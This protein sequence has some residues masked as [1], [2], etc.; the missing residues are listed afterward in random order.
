MIKHIVCF[1]LKNDSIELRNK[2]RDILL[3]M[4]GRVPMLLDLEVGID[5]LSSQRS[6]DII[7]ETYFNN[8]EDL[9]KY[10]NDPYHCEVVKTHM[11]ANT[12]ASIAVD[13]EIES[14]K[15][16]IDNHK[17]GVDFWNSKRELFEAFYKEF[18]EFI[19]NHNGKEDLEK[20]KIFSKEDFYAY[21]DWYADNQDSCYAM[22]F[23]FHK[24]YL[25]PQERGKIENQPESTFIG[26]CFKNNKFIDFLDRKSVV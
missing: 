8:K 16:E 24:Y 18:Y 3:S 12:T 17:I 6:Y 7:L 15:Y 1:K 5:F 20:H 19:L 9:E 22:G 11:H 23:S 14:F 4:K 26:Y 25:T 10:Q 21:A 2:T 13:Y